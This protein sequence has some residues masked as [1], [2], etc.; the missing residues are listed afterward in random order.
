MKKF[1]SVLKLFW[2]RFKSSAPRFFKVYGAVLTVLTALA[3]YLNVQNDL[4]EGIEKKHVVWLNF[5]V[6]VLGLLA[7]A[8]TTKDK[9][10]SEVKTEEDLNRYISNRQTEYKPK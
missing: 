1:S 7:P 3:G 8:L 2:L 5:L 6:F 9:Q 10:L 4:P